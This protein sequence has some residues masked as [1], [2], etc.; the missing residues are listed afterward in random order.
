MYKGNRYVTLSEAAMSDLL[1]IGDRRKIK[2]GTVAFGGTAVGRINNMVVFVPFAVDG[3]EAE[4][5]IVEVKKNYCTG[6]IRNIISPSRERV[7][8]KCFYYSK[9]G[10]CQYQHISYEHQLTI[11]ERQVSES[12]ER[13]GRVASPPVNRIIPSPGIFNYRGKADFHIG[14]DE[15]GSPHIGFMNEGGNFPVDI[16]KCEIV[17]ETINAAFRKFRDE[18]TAGKSNIRGSRFVFWSEK[19]FRA[20]R[21]IERTVKGKK[22]KVPYSGFFQANMSLVEKLVD[23]V[24]EMGDFDGSETVVDCYCGSGLFSLFIAP[25][26]RKVFGIE[27]DGKSLDC[28]SGNLIR[29]GLSN[30]Q[31]FKG[32]V[33][34]ILR[35]KF[36]EKKLPVN[37]VLLDPPRVGCSKGVLD[38]IIKIK[39]EKLI[40]ISCNPATQAR[41]IRYL[42]DRDFSLKLIQPIDMFPQTK[43]IEVIATME[44]L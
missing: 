37:T 39:P 13:I 32:N 23:C 19:D 2:I 17:D 24:I 5:G 25:R 34:E 29:Y 27:R 15:K 20:H 42:I 38:D 21:K 33:E 43:H 11:K 10:G 3:D 1:K 41:D 40:Y 30:T 4:I 36:V 28:A 8:P 7:E 22:L 44:T 6:E 14:F 35:E 26:V 9:C 12:F 31:F 18:I 16:K